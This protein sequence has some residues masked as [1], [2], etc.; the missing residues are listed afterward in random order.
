MFANRE[1]GTRL[2]DG[3]FAT[4]TLT[5][6]V[7]VLKGIKGVW[8]P[9]QRGLDLYDDEQVLANGYLGDVSAVDG[10]TFQLVANPVQFDEQPNALVRAPELGEHTDDVLRG[11]GYDD[12]AIIALKVGNAIL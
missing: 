3:I 2:L 5:E 4:R 9:V 6:W 8:A 11:I 7:E 1:E 10:S 12:E